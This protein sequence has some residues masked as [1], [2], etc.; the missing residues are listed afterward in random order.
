[1]RRDTSNTTASTRLLALDALRGFDMFWL[2]GGE[3]LPA[4][5]LTLTGWPW[6]AALTAQFQHSAWHG[7]RFYDLIFP[8]FIFIAGVAL[9]LPGRS[10][11]SLSLSER[12]P[13]YR[14]AFRRVLLLLALGI[15]YNHGWGS[16]LPAALDEIRYASVLGR[17]GIAWLVTALIVWHCRIAVQR[18]ALP[19]ALLGYSLVQRQWPL[20][21][22]ESLNALWDQA[23]LPGRR[24]RDAAFDPEGLYSQF[25]AILICWFGALIGWHWRQLD[26]TRKQRWRL[27]GLALLL[28][29]VGVLLDPF[30]PIN[31][32]LWT[33]SFTLVS[34]GASLLLLQLF[35]AAL[36]E[37]GVSWSAPLHWLGSNAILAYLGTS[38]IA[39]AYT[40][41]SLFGGWLQAAPAS[42]QPLLF[43][44]LV[45]ALQLLLLRQLYQRQW[46]LRL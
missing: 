34:A 32:P 15:V 36:G 9:G 38:L 4:A 3:L 17:I 2:I 12:A 30:Y 22:T 27:T 24:Y 5:L 13:H 21:D 11:R 14:K 7:F 43:A 46:F 10:L 23:W 26:A 45:L 37:E 19:L 1:M 18:Y 28:I 25:G 31:K 39:W 42:L 33:G 40:V 6:L 20:T 35:A 16:G 44:L 41:R 29:V 8:L